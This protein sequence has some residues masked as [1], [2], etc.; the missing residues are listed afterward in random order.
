M[1]R[2]GT[3]LIE[4]FWAGSFSEDDDT[5]GGGSGAGDDGGKGAG[6][7]KGGEEKFDAAY[8]KGLRDE[9]A[10]HRREAKSLAESLKSLE[11]SQ[12]SESEKRDQRAKELETENTRLKSEQRE[13]RIEATAAKAGARDP[14]LI[15]KLVP[16]DAED[17]AKAIAAIKKERPHLFSGVGS[18]DGGAGGGRTA[19]GQSM[20]DRIRGARG[21]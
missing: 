19:S 1:R 18:A 3:R 17:V 5:G 6:D 15:A 4:D 8:V 12:L 16:A 13:A 7:G 14:D 2:F 9:A 20:N 10:K 11:D 21:G